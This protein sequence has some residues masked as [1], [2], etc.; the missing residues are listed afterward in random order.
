MKKITDDSI[1][2]I[3]KQYQPAQGYKI[4]TDTTYRGFGLRIMAR[5][6]KNPDG[7]VSFVFNYRSPSGGQERRMTIGNWP[8]WS[9][10]DAQE[11]KYEIEDGKKTLKADGWFQLRQKVRDDKLDPM[12][13]VIQKKV[14]TTQAEAKTQ[15]ES[16][17][18]KDLVDNYLLKPTTRK[19][20]RG[21]STRTIQ[22]E[23]QL[24][25]SILLKKFGSMPLS[26][27]GREH[28][29]ELHRELQAT[30][31]HS[32][33][34]RS[35]MSLLFSRAM[36]LARDPVSGKQ[37][38]QITVNPVTGTPRHPE[39]KREAFL[40]PDELKRLKKAIASYPGRDCAQAIELLMRTGARRGELLEAE[41]NEFDLTR[42]I[43]T[44]PEDKTKQKQKAP[45]MLGPYTLALLQ[46]MYKAK[47]AREK[48]AAREKLEGYSE[49]FLFPG[50]NQR[51][52]KNRVTLER[53]WKQIS[54]A[55]KLEKPGRKRE[56]VPKYRIHDLRHNFASALASDGESLTVIGKIMGHASIQTTSRYA[57]LSDAAQQRA[58]NRSDEL[59]GE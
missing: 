44:R 43:W 58:V 5:S 22:E 18:F 21:K 2:Q 42:G 54:K 23:K 56:P 57:H 20:P 11:G 26:A 15:A 12:E 33:R 47:L 34:C 37:W 46:K 35:L 50:Q 16:R 10:L 13:V 8:E 39:K 27:I 25:D 3:V 31:Y 19:N 48:Q 29:E 6:E 14:A 51:K 28:L 49:L 59:I 53:A 40:T 24:L 30:P 32:N 41:W 9:V 38:P 36:D 45:V 17:T 1:K 55:A 7:G 4:V 52:G